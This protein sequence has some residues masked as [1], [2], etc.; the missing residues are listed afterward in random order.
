MTYDGRVA[1]ISNYNKVGVLAA[2]FSSAVD[3]VQLPGNS[4]VE[5]ESKLITNS[6]ALDERGGLY[7]VNSLYMCKA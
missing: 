3:P 4:E 7:I 1:W 5:H 6:F 2:D